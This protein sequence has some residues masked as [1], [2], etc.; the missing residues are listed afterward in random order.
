MLECYITLRWKG[1][2]WQGQ[3]LLHIRYKENEVIRI[4][5]LTLN[6]DDLVLHSFGIIS[7]VSGIFSNCIEK[8][9]AK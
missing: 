8:V 4:W 2:P 6:G 1:L 7:L 9:P 5:P 3:K